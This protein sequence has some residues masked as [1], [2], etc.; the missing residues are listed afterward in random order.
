MAIDSLVAKAE[1]V[2]NIGRSGE[3]YRDYMTRTR[4]S[5]LFVF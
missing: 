3:V 4:L 2:E 5:I 1:E